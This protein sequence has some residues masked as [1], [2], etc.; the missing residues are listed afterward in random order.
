MWR[1][2]GK[3]FKIVVSCWSG[4][5][6]AQRCYFALH[7][8]GNRSYGNRNW[9]FPGRICDSKHF[10]WKLQSIFN[11]LFKNCSTSNFCVRYCRNGVIFWVCY[12]SIFVHISVSITV[13]WLCL[14]SCNIARLFN[15][16]WCKCCVYNYVKYVLRNSAKNQV[17]Y[18]PNLCCVTM[19]L[20]HRYCRKKSI[21]QNEDA[22]TH[23]CGH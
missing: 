11:L 23:E 6:K 16:T 18:S 2:Q 14:H 21:E 20:Q 5:R 10:W 22:I 8:L 1:V 3:L 7:K 12:H 17:W 9:F 13:Q 19:T 15:I 4:D